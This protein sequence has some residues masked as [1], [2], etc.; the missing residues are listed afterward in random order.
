MTQQLRI[1]FLDELKTVRL[2]CRQKDCGTTTELPLAKLTSGVAECK[3]AGCG[4]K[5][6]IGYEQGED[7]LNALVSGLRA[8]HYMN[9]HNFAV[10]FPLAE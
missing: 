6:G 5:F 10:Q 2:V 8:L 3:C 9:E 7:P 1:V 4:R